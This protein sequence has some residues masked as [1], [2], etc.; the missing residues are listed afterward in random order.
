MKTIA[1]E[2]LM[3]ECILTFCENAAELGCPRDKEVDMWFRYLS[4]KDARKVAEKML[5]IIERQPIEPIEPIEPI[6]EIMK[7]EKIIKMV[8]MELD[9]EGNIIDG[10][11]KYAVE[12]IKDDKRALLNWAVNDIFARIINNEDEFARIAKIAKK[13]KKAKAIQKKSVKPKRK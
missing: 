11:V 7:K 12:G 5:E 8:E 9:L 1:L 2:D 6:G 3:I 10:L 13:A 4:H